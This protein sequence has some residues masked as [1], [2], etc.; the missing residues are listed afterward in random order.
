MRSDGGVGGIRH[1]DEAAV[2]EQRH[3]NESQIHG[4]IARNRRHATFEVELGTLKSDRIAGGR[5]IRRRRRRTRG[6][7]C[8]K[9]GPYCILTIRARNSSYCDEISIVTTTSVDILIID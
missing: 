1:E 4:V 6:S 9:T 5:G 2:D 3:R 7:R 8:N